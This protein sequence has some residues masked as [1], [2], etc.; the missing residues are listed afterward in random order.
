MYF[1]CFAKKSTKRRR[2]RR[3]AEFCAP[4]QKDALSYVPL[5]SRI[6]VVR[7]NFMGKDSYLVA[8]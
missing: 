8:F 7:N 1:S 5:P 3:G 6:Y 4:A 2:H